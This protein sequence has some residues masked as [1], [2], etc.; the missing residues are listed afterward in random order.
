MVLSFDK[1]L[2][3][4]FLAVVLVFV[5]TLGKRAGRREVQALMVLAEPFLEHDDGIHHIERPT[6]TEATE[7][8]D[9]VTQAPPTPRTRAATDCQRFTAGEIEF[10]EPQGY[11]V[12]PDDFVNISERSSWKVCP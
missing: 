5:Y 3:F 1:M 2:G 12:W 8:E 4:F 6:Q 9:G 11:E 10:L 7:T